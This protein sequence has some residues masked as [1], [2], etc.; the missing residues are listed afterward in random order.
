[1]KIP[2]FH[3]GNSSTVLRK[4]SYNDDFARCGI[5]IYGY[6]HIHPSFGNFPL[7]RVLKLYAQ[8]ISTRFLKKGS[9]VGYNG[10]GIIENDTLVST[11][12]VG[13]GDGLFE[14]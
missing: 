9:R 1:M 13:Y 6:E 4:Q 5:S 3:S 11:Y 12:D 8:K 10:A 14:K 2:L 7:K